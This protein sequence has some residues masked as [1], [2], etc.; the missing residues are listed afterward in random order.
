MGSHTSR[1]RIGGAS[2][3]ACR[4]E[5]PESVG[6]GGCGG[7][8]S[9]SLSLPVN[10]AVCPSCC[11]LHSALRYLLGKLGVGSGGEKAAG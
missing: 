1:S 9:H 4:G 11:M 7:G 8:V 6:A 2:L 3:S 10:S 5:V